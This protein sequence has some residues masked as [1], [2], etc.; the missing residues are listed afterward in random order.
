M[1]FNLDRAIR[2]SFRISQCTL[3]LALMLGT[4]SI[5]AIPELRWEG[6]VFMYVTTA[7]SLYL[8]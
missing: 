3:L 2:W 7:S 8:E 6:P 5:A 4:A 1:S